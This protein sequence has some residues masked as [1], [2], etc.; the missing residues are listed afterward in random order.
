MF[1]YLINDSYIAHDWASGRWVLLPGWTPGSPLPDER[2]ETPLREDLYRRMGDVSAGVY[3]PWRLRGEHEIAAFF[4]GELGHCPP[5]AVVWRYGLAG[6]RRQYPA[7]EI[8]RRDG[9]R[10]VVGR[11][12]DGPSCWYL[13]GASTFVG[14][15]DWRVAHDGDALRGNL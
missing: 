3:H 6:E 5:R 4:R 13:D 8:V 1:V 2:L 14:G 12:Q 10:E 11:G 9:Q 15:W 7:I